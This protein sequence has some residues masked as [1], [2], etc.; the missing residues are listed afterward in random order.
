MAPSSRH[1]NGL[2]LQL[3]RVARLQRP[4]PAVRTAVG[5]TRT[6][7]VGHSRDHSWDLDPANLKTIHGHHARVMHHF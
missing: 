5:T 3:Q 2:P 7:G 4:E 1:H 6:T